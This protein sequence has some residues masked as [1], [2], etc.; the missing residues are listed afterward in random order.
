MKTYYEN[1]SLD[2]FNTFPMIIYLLLFFFL[3]IYL[4]KKLLLKD[5]KF[6]KF[7]FIAILSIYFILLLGDIKYDYIPFFPDTEKYYELLMDFSKRVSSIELNIGFGIFSRFIYLLSF[8]NI[9][10]YILANALIN[11][12]GILLLWKA[13]RI[14]K[15][16][17]VTIK[18]QR[19]FLIF[20]FIYPV[21]IIYSLT[22]LRE[23]YFIFAFSV[24][25]IG[26]MKST[27]INIYTILGAILVVIFRTKYIMFCGIVYFMKIVFYD[28]KDI[29]YK[30]GG[31][32]VLSPLIYKFIDWFSTKSMGIALN[33]TS[34]R[35]FRNEQMIRYI[36]TGFAYPRVDWNSWMDILKDYPL[37]IAQFLFSPLPILIEYDFLKSIGYTLDAFF[38]IIVLLLFLTNIRNNYKNTFWIVTL[39]A[40]MLLSSM[41]EYFLTGGVRH[42]YALILMFIPLLFSDKKENEFNENR[43]FNFFS[44]SK[45]YK[46]IDFTGKKYKSQNSYNKSNKE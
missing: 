26:I 24:F 46:T 30:V 36:N 11:Q 33:V 31:I 18:N 34:L 42:R 9:G 7:Y 41:F 23:S 27:K 37:L 20:S 14:Y 4:S 16:D 3:L 38:V 2:F 10:I 6:N 21:S 12:I 39:L 45:K 35:E 40:I 44:K 19:L 5:E 32:I 15:K 8:K 29:K 22:L 1:I 13:F 28:G 43:S 25:L 17:K